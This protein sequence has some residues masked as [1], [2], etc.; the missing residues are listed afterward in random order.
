MALIE[1]PEGKIETIIPIMNGALHA[2]L[3]YG[4]YTDMRD[5]R[6]LIINFNVEVG[7]ME[8]VLN[9]LD[10]VVDT[11]FVPKKHTLIKEGMLESFIADDS[12]WVNPI[13]GDIVKYANQSPTPEMELEPYAKQY[14]WFAHISA[15]QPM[16]V[17]DFIEQ[18]L[19]QKIANNELEIQKF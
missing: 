11:I 7:I 19:H 14:N 10:E 3:W 15:N 5:E 1:L 9:E 8:D 16:L 4:N 6:R 13:N 18:L 2:R 17:D 12:T